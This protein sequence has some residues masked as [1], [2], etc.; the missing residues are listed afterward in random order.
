[1]GDTQ[2][3]QRE[4]NTVKFQVNDCL[5]ELG[6]MSKYVFLGCRGGGRGMETKI[7][8]NSMEIKKNRGDANTVGAF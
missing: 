4:K 1:M 8:C 2:H 5:T 7:I 6:K 3:L